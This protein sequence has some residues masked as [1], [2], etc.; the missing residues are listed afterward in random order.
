MRGDL[1]DPVSRRGIHS[2][3]R[4]SGGPDGVKYFDNFSLQQLYVGL[5]TVTQ[6]DGFRKL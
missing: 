5:R 3:G 6:Y 1:A 4:I 2:Y